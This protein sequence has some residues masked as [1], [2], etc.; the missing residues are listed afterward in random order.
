LMF[1]LLYICSNFV[2]LFFMFS[3]LYLNNLLQINFFLLFSIKNT[4]YYI[5]TKLFNLKSQ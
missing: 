4:I 5:F 1:P 2:R 3:T